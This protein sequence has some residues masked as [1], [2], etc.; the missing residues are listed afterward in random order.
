MTPHDDCLNRF[1][2]LK[3]ST[4]TT[5]LISPRIPKIS[6]G[7]SIFYLK[8]IKQII[9]QIIVNKF[10]INVST[11]RAMLTLF[12]NFFFFS[13]ILGIYLAVLRAHS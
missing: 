4:L 6:K 7:N 13:L 9:K 12:P 5:T 3:R 2:S 11:I 10:L 1:R 8:K